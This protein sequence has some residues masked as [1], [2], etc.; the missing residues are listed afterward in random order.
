MKGG[1]TQVVEM[2]TNKDGELRVLKGAALYGPM[3][4]AD[5]EHLLDRGRLEPTDQ[6]S[7]SDGPWM[8][9]GGYLALGR[10][11]ADSAAPA[12][13][14]AA[15]A[16]PV[17][18][19]G[20]LRLFSSL[21]R[22]QIDELRKKGRVDDD[23]LVCAQNGPWMRLGDFFAPPAAVARRTVMQAKQSEPLPRAESTVA[24][25]D[26]VEAVEVVEPCASGEDDLEV[27]HVPGGHHVADLLNPATQLSDDWFVRVKGIHSAPLKKQ[28]VKMLFQAR[29]ITLDCLAR[30]AS[31][32][33]GL[34]VP[35]QTIPDL[36]DVSAP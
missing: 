34:W 22:E 31:W 13:S 1:P 21:S 17:P 18:K 7:V 20:D 24:P 30:H 33:D 36:A 11:A 29:E 16:R 23:D 35:I 3:T 19:A 25:E 27:L 26:L 10:Q 28:H 8:A 9:I 4:R 5:L 15:P 12:Q 6:V 2:A 14:A 32:R